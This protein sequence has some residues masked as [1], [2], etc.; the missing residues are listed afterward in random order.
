MSHV[1]PAKQDRKGVTW[2]WKILLMKNVSRGEIHKKKCSESANL[3]HAYFKERT[4]G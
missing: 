2:F 4:T 3:R 1:A